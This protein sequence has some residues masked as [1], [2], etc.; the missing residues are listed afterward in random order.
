MIQRQQR[1]PSNTFA[2]CRECGAE[3]SHIEARGSST[4][5]AFDV[6][7]PTGTR[8]ALECGCGAH[9][10]WLPTL[11]A[12]TAHWRAHFAT[13][14]RISVRPILRLHRNKETA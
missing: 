9:T 11:A 7:R 4:R 12:A 2:T 6:T 1:H 10:G 14:E 3:P 8:H 5:E 13:P